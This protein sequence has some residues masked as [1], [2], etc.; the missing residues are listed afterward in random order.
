MGR[1]SDGPMFSCC[2]FLAN[3]APL[4]PAIDSGGTNAVCTGVYSPALVGEGGEVFLRVGRQQGMHGAAGGG[5]WEGRALSLA[6]V[7]PSEEG[8]FERGD[9]QAE[10]D[11]LGFGGAKLGAG[12]GDEGD[13][14]GA[15]CYVFWWRKRGLIWV[16]GSA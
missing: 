10:G 13:L 5:G 9:L 16:W 6:V 4:M 14:L 11:V 2:A 15:V 1:F 3:I 8:A 7:A 12:G